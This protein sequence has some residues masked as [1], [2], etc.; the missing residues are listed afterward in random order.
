MLLKGIIT[1]ERKVEYQPLI[2][3]LK[4]H[5]IWIERITLGRFS[6]EEVEELEEIFEEAVTGAE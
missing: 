1:W 6:E 5:K 3:H 4:I 2:L